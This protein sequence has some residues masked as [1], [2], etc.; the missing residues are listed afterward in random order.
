MT[1][2]P[3]DRVNTYDGPGT[4]RGLD[5]VHPDGVESYRVKLDSGTVACFDTSRMVKATV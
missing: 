4:V 1:F 3:N 2:A 5:I